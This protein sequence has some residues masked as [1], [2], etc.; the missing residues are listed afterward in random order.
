MAGSKVKIISTICTAQV[1]CE[2]NY[3]QP[4]RLAKGRTD[5]GICEKA[6]EKRNKVTPLKG[7]KLYPED[8]D[9]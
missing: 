6:V 1:A 9:G 3:V 2:G 8:S 7:I 4:K 5:C